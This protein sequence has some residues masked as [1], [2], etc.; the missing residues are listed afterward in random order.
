MG[1][2]QVIKLSDTLQMLPRQVTCFV[3]GA[4]PRFLDEGRRKGLQ[5]PG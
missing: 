2:L 3:H 5:P 1:T 4:A